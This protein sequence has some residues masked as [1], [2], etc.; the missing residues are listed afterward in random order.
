METGL[1]KERIVNFVMTVMEDIDKLINEMK[2][3]LNARVNAIDEE[4]L[5]QV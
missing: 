2:I 3:N 1:A 5:K 4:L